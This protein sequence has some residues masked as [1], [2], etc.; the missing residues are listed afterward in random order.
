MNQIQAAFGVVALLPFSAIAGAAD[1]PKERCLADALRMERAV[2]RQLEEMASIGSFRDSVNRG[3]RA[4]ESTGYPESGRIDSNGAYSILGGT[5][6]PA[7]P[8]S[9]VE[10][11]LR[12][13]LQLLAARRLQ[14]LE[15][16]DSDA[17]MA[18]RTR[19]VRG[20]AVT[21][22]SP[23]GKPRAQLK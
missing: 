21:G 14:C 16:P 8:A 5:S 23:A 6:I 19:V 4:V 17:E 15:L 10:M 2:S 3:V 7:F 20:G 13:E 1:S 18:L 12:R 22:R 9:A 11:L